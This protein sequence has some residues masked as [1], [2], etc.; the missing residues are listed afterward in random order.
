[1]F[2]RYFL[3]ISMLIPVLTLRAQEFGGNPPTIK[4]KQINTDTVRII[5]PSGL[6]TPAQRAVNTIHYLS[7]NNRT[8]IGT[9]QIKVNM[10]LQNQTMTSNGYVGLAPFRSEFQ[11]SA[12]Q[13]SFRLGALNWL[14][15]LSIH[16]YRHVL[17]NIN[18]RY[19]ISKLF[20]YLAG[21]L[22]WA[23][24]TNLSIPDWFWEG[25]AVIVETALTSQGRGRIPAFFN[26][27]RSLL[28]SDQ[29][30]D[31]QKAR[32]GSYKDYVPNHY[33]LGYLL[34]RYGRNRYGMD[35]W[36]D[37]FRNAADYQSV[38]Y[39]FSRALKKKTGETTLQF[40]RSAMQ[41]LDQKWENEMDTTQLSTARL[42]NREQDNV[43]TYKYPYLLENGNILVLKSSYQ[44]IATWY[45]LTPDGRENQ[46][47]A[48][49][50]T[51]DDYYS[52]R[53]NRMVWSELSFDE[54]WG[55]QEKTN[56]RL[57]NFNDRSKKTVVKNSRYY[58][59]DISPDGA[60][61]VA[62]EATP[63]LE[64]SLNILDAGNGRLLR[65]LPNPDGLLY[66]YPKWD[67]D[68]NA[69]IAS[70][71]DN[72]GRMALIR[73]NVESGRIEMLTDWTNHLFGIPHVTTDYIYFT[74]TFS[75]VDNLYAFDRENGALLKVSTRPIGAYQ[76][77]TDAAA[78]RILFSE[79][80][81]DGYDLMEMPHDP[82]RWEEVNVTPLDEMERFRFSGIEEEGGNILTQIP[83]KQ[84]PVADYP[85]TTNLINFHSWQ[86]LPVDPN[87]RLSILSD[88]ILNTLSVSVGGFY[89]RNENNI[90]FTA[91][92]SYGGFYPVIN[93][94]LRTRLA[95]TRDSIYTRND[96]V[97][98]LDQ[99]WNEYT[100]FGG[101]SFPFN[102]TSGQ[103]FR[104]LTIGANYEFTAIDYY[105][106]QRRYRQ[107]FFLNSGSYFFQFNNRRKRALQNIFPAFAQFVQAEYNLPF[108]GTNAEQLYLNGEFAFPGLITNHSLVLQASYQ[109][110]GFLND[111]YY[112]NNFFYPRGYGSF[113]LYDSFWKLGANYHLPL[114]YPDFG[115]LGIIYFYR[116]RTNLFYDHGHYNLF[117]F[118]E[119]VRSA[120]AELI[121]DTQI[122]N[123]L[124]INFGVRYS[125]LFDLGADNQ[126]D[127]FFPLVRF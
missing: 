22:G 125:Y 123:V 57:Y 3:I 109:K 24:A 82:E 86:F 5:F 100:V 14:D 73:Q 12:P 13:Q 70:A 89:N 17:Q 119:E 8:S 90:G 75:G 122:L 54:R 102:L 34:S 49:G 101:L 87:Y 108:D 44:Q 51:I 106:P 35:M 16:E 37:V 27:Y 80:T 64:F 55:W 32:N 39:P 7:R 58:S 2:A 65:K 26:G 28:L 116:V 36:K 94:G 74:A 91:D 115:V 56:I 23:G 77:A 48:Q 120:G 107:D 124:P 69:I 68:E 76:P 66:T 9:A 84:Y 45:Q 43:T 105:E 59:P 111:Y 97:R 6:E 20:Y 71:R 79:F 83:E 10:V 1:M 110:E 11:L 92:A 25:D 96:R 33:E 38:F 127:F 41:H 99:R 30:Y 104:D 31:Y 50:I 117:D 19:G 112:P 63:N 42:I 126:I 62:F 21:E 46:M 98:F 81:A 67:L 40:Y 29:L 4:W 113:R 88:N 53:N 93:A 47:F 52:Y 78:S 15:L 95:R 72:L 121:F 18:A 114:L 103:Y 61:I 60:R 85:V 118:S